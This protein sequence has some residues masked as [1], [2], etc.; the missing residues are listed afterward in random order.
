[1]TAKNPAYVGHC[2]C[3]TVEISAWAQP[4]MVSTCYC[5][6]C[7]AAGQR[8]AASGSSAPMSGADGG[9][10]FM[11]FRR[12]SIACTRGADL[13]QPAKLTSHTKTRRMIASCCATPMY[14]AFDDKRPWVSAFRAPFG[15]DAPPVEMRICTRFRRAEEAVDD[16]VR[17]HS[18]YPPAMMVRILAALPVVL[19]SK[20]VGTL[21]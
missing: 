19:F 21:P 12:G 9:T 5:D 2:Q 3:G 1:M 18:G 14:V 17:S 11:V 6:D 15:A 13:L 10:E 4:M 8:H 7:Q 16:G 20:S